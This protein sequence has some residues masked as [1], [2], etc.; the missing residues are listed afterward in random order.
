ME[1]IYLGFVIFL[2]MLAI[3]DLWVGVSN[4]AVNF[5]NSAIGSKAAKFRTIII[6]AAIGIFF[7]ATMSNGM[8]DIARHGIFNPS[9]FSFQDVMFIFLAVMAAD[10]ILLDVFNTMGMPTSTTVSMVFELLGA[11]FAFSIMK[12]AA[13][14]GDGNLNDYMNTGKALSVIMAIFVSVAI[15]FFF[16]L[17]I[18]YIARLIFTFRFKEKLKWTV[19]IFAGLAVTS[20][21]YFMLI[22][23]IKSLSF[24]TDD[25]KTWIHDNSMLIIGGCFVFFSIL[26]QILHWLKVNVLKIVVLTGTFALA[27]AFAGNDLVNFI[28]VP[29]T[30]FASFQDYMAS[31]STNPE[32]FMMDSLNDSAHTPIVFLVGAGIIMVLALVFS[33]KA[34]NVTKTE[35]SLAK[36]ESGEEIFGSSKAARSLVRW[37]SSIAMTMSRITPERTKRWIEKRFDSTTIEIEDGAAYDL[38][39]ASVNLVVASLLIA[40]GTSLK[41]PLS[42][43]YVTFMVAMGSSLAD[44]AWG[45][46]SAVFRITGVLSVIG[47]WFITAG[48][49]FTLCFVFAMI[50]YFGGSVAA[51][52][53]VAISTFILIRSNINYGKKHKEEKES[54]K[55]FREIVQ[56]KNT[57]EAWPVFMQHTMNSEIELLDENT[58]AYIKITNALFNENLKMARKADSF[59]KKEKYK[60]KN[61]R[62]K[63]TLCLRMI[64]PGTAVEKGTWFHM[65][66]NSM[67]QMHYSIRRIC[68]PVYEH[69]E[70][71]FSPLEQKYK[72]EFKPERDNL[73][74]ILKSVSESV[75]KNKCSNAAELKEQC[76]MMQKRFS[77][78]RN[79]LTAEMHDNA[80]INLTVAYLYLNIIQESEQLAVQTQQLVRASEKFY[81]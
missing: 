42:T 76:S 54:D 38:I 9:Q 17:L 31:G 63:E 19:G 56:N 64:E 49:A 66:H 78:M 61:I 58:D 52:I 15:A 34:H 71:N 70:N 30:G 27:T 3:F 33:K 53:I 16:G 45:R 81:A 55:L 20:I 65:L 21:I 39:R 51:I 18:Q 29:L 25:V 57:P 77:D 26:M 60:L 75:R 4:D 67:E 13:F 74:A 2:F 7:G 40:L 62:R 68:E 73:T 79:R 10:I 28:G 72:N 12:I 47:G 11:S 24:M 69:M 59:M 46:E 22:K 50:M 44:R 80:G 35:I 14:D 37:G 48:A 23:G 6:I 41:L 43:T 5:L 1:W 36:Q 32:T 8:M